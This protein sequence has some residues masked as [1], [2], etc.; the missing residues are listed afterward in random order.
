MAVTWPHVVHLISRVQAAVKCKWSVKLFWCAK[1]WEKWQA[2]L[3]N[4]FR[5]IMFS[6]KQ[7][8]CISSAVK[9]KVRNTITD[10]TPMFPCHTWAQFR[11]VFYCN[12]IGNTDNIP[13]QTTAW[14]MKNS[15]Q[16]YRMGSAHIS[17]I[18][19][20]MAALD[21]VIWRFDSTWSYR[22]PVDSTAFTRSYGVT[23]VKHLGLARFETDW[24]HCRL[25]AM[26][27]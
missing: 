22:R 9:S 2:L 5:S 13:F 3:H 1:L 12:Q 25:V 6:K 18:H 27:H 24:R 15:R 21:S 20:L 19:S 23:T 17:K 7:V 16:S 26:Q 4:G 11:G 8:K 10:T 14:N